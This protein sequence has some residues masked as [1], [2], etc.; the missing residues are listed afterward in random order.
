M[1]EATEL[2][3][4][5]LLR[6]SRAQCQA[7]VNWVGDQQS[8]FDVL[9][10]FF[11]GS[12]ALLSQR[13]AWALSYCVQAHPAFITKHWKALLNIL[14]DS[15]HHPAIRRNGFRLMQDLRIPKRY[16]GKA[17]DLCFRWIE[18]PGEPVAIKA[19]AVTVLYR[20]SIDYP[21]II[22]EIRTVIEAVMPHESIAFRNRAGKLLKEWNKR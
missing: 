16:Q 4:I 3:D 12:D 7:A 1:N 5:L 17:M 14:S 22:P 15:L 6:H 2:K 18:K 10:S 8:R 11:A 19:F 9:F 13:A 21:E 20:L